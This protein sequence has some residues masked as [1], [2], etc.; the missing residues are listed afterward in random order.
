MSDKAIGTTLKQL[1]MGCMRNKGSA[2]TCPYCHWEETGPQQYL[3][4]LPLRTVLNNRF[5]IGRVLSEGKFSITYLAYHLRA[6][7]KLVIKEFYPRDIARR[8]V[9][10]PNLILSDLKHEDDF[11]FGLGKFIEE[12][13]ALEK[14]KY[15]PGLARGQGSVRANGTAYQL[16]EFIEGPHLQEYLAGKGGQV[17]FHHLVRILTPVIIALEKAHEHYVLHHDIYPEN[18]IVGRDG[19]GTLVDFTATRFELAQKWNILPS[20]SRPGYSP[21]EFYSDS[22]QVGP[23]SD[24]YS[25][26]ATMYFA[27]TGQVPPPAPDRAK[28]E[29]LLPPDE[30]GADISRETETVLLKALSLNPR[31]R[32]PNLKAFK[33]SI[34]ESWYTWE[35]KKPS[36]AVEAFTRAK[37][38]YCGVVNE[39]LRTDLETGTTACFACH[40]PLVSEDGTTFPSAP[41]VPQTPPVSAEPP[42][43]IPPVKVRIKQAPSRKE[44]ALTSAKEAFT[45]V[46]CLA[47][48]TKNEVLIS[49]LGTIAQCSKC[50]AR[51]PAPSAAPAPAPAPPPPP[52]PALPESPPELPVEK[53][54]PA[55]AITPGMAGETG[56]AEAFAAAPE[57]AATAPESV[58]GIEAAPPPAGVEEAAARDRAAEERIP[59]RE[60]PKEPI[61]IPT[62]EETAPRRPGRAIAEPEPAPPAAPEK[63]KRQ[64]QTGPLTPLDC[65]ECQ[66][67]NYFTIEEILSGVNCEKC[68]YRFFSQPAEEKK[69]FAGIRRQR[70]RQKIPRSRKLM[71]TWV[72]I[73]I[74]VLLLTG[75]I[76]TYRF[77]NEGNAQSQAYR[78]YIEQADRLFGEGNYPEALGNYRSAL[79]LEPEE[80]YL[81]AQIRECERLLA[82][83]EKKSEEQKRQDLFTGQ[84][85]RAD[86]LFA[87][88]DLEAARFA[89][90]AALQFSPEDPYILNRLNEINKPPASPPRAA[91]APAN[92]V[93]VTPAANL[94]TTIDRAE[95][96]TVIQLGQGIFTLSKPL[97]I[98]KAIE[99]RGAGPNHTLIISGAGETVLLIQD[100]GQFSAA[101]IGF[102]H[103]GEA[104]ADVV[105]VKNTTANFNNC[106]FKGGVYNQE[107]RSGGSGLVFEGSSRG[108]VQNSRF[109]GNYIAL[110]IRQKSQPLLT[111]NEIWG[112]HI[113]VQISETS[114]P[115]LK[116]NRIRENFN[117]GIAI[118]DQAQPEIETNQ[119]TDNKANGLFFYGA[120][121]NGAI[122]NNQIFNNRDLGIL[123]TNES[124]PT[125]E[126]NKIQWNGMGGIQYNDR[127]SGIARYN[128][129]QAN[130]SGGVKITNSSQ[131]TLKENIIKGNH[132]DGIEISDKAAPTVD[133]NEIIQ[134]S[135]DG[136]SLLLSNPGGFLSNNIC[137]GNQGYGISILK[138]ARPT[139]VNNQLQGNYEGV[140]YEETAAA[141]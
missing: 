135:G 41:A 32:F 103:Q 16:T 126:S 43:T 73:F 25:L 51:L 47:C 136:I 10:N 63:R 131:P 44:E 75:G 100:A 139:L 6:R 62:E 89:Y 137:K 23:W 29:V 134:N 3:H 74:G 78:Y 97:R 85:N 18:I 70:R 17:S 60:S 92:R 42:P 140:L 141:N 125:I 4:H 79:V 68:G 13:M 34:L 45:L 57:P 132:G 76:L 30:F 110:N 77:V 1:C 67:R 24:I 14:I 19:L 123:L 121:F 26:A 101:N 90:E 105:R 50:G 109:N 5:L 133:R 84:L 20:L 108:K 36:S 2:K 130:K 82:E 37:C 116:S 129:I 35:R 58:P 21:P 80:P 55:E 38:P 117:N 99:L 22:P 113:G 61:A 91:A 9:G 86:S 124:Q 39:V 53:A 111:G 95:A 71:L 114:R 87:A 127:A 94:Q 122:R 138:P 104:W 88:G 59:R 46:P 106:M 119:V 81:I 48:G 56:I 65:P 7:Q 11:N 52:S 40:H 27:L 83:F 49:D 72:S 66:T 28:K 107:Q 93:S 96:N 69:V 128:V 33:E 98:N 15:L 118:L 120:K 112:N 12:G 54:P 115:V 102:E 31:D 64:P 8:K